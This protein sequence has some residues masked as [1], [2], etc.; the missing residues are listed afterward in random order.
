M[1]PISPSHDTISGMDRPSL[2]RG[3]RIVV[4]AVL[5]IL[6]VLLIA[7]WV[8]SYRWEDLAY[9][10]LTPQKIFTLDSGGG[11]LNLSIHL[12][13]NR[14]WRTGVVL[15]GTGWLSFRRQAHEDALS[16]FSR[17]WDQFNYGVR[18]PHLLPVLVSATLAVAPW[19]RWRFTVRTL[20]IAT[21]IFAVV[22]GLV[23]GA[24]R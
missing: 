24:M 20:L 15:R 5:G 16:M 9:C 4:S 17:R 6:C 2:F 3:L 7:L 12:P 22:L 8:R 23:V 1:A 11:R 13:S 14:P 18:F 10:Q 21:T 19:V